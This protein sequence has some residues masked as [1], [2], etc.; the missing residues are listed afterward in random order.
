MVVGE[1]GVGGNPTNPAGVDVGNIPV[2]K[3]RTNAEV[4]FILENHV[5]ART[6]HILENCVDVGTVHVRTGM[7]TGV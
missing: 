3:N 6:V 7:L 2:H 4:A 1:I 5:D